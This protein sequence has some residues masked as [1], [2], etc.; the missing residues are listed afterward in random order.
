MLILVLAYGR[1]ST[2]MVFS[3]KGNWVI[4]VKTGPTGHL[5]AIDRGQKKTMVF[6][7][8]QK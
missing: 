2:T 1:T 4:W 3:K 8:G 5:W 6:D 7:R